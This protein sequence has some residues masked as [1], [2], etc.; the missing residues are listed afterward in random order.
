MS[1]ALSNNLLAGESGAN[2]LTGNSGNDLLFGAAGADTLNGGQGAD[3]LAG[4]TG[5]DSLNG[6]DGNDVLVGGTGIDTLNGGTGADIL[7]GGDGADAIYTGAADDSF[8]DLI[9]FSAASEYGDTISGFDVSGTLD[10]IE[11]TG[12]LNTLFDDG[13]NND[14][15]LFSTGNGSA[16]TVSVTV[17]QANGNA[18]ALLL[19]GANS[20]GVTNA[21]LTSAAAVAAAFNAEFNI[22]AANGE[23]ALLVINDT[24]ANS[25]SL[26]QWV[27]AGGGEISAAELTLIATVSANGT[28]VA[29]DFDFA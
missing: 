16:G 10:R 1:V 9:Q 5:A 7:I 21:N 22:T 8:V 20:E 17:G 3:L 4:G 25:A 23:D 27:Q 24:N 6:G 29:G 2:R 14:N 13:N 19:T 26:W 12:A 18:E 11:F 15:F 28:V